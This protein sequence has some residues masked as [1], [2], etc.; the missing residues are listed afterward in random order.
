MSA[1]TGGAAD[2]A[3]VQ[4]IERPVESVFM[5]GYVRDF[6]RADVIAQVNGRQVRSRDEVDDLVS[7]AEREKPITFTF[8]SGGARG[9]RRTVQITPTLQ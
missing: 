5:R 1:L 8:R 4:P 3:G 7:R 2:K 6:E 9:R